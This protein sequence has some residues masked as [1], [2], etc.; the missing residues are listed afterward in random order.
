LLQQLQERFEGFGEGAKAVLQGR[1]E[2]AL[3]G[4]KAHAVAQGLEVKPEFGAA[5][6]ALLGS[7]A[8]AV[9]VSDGAVARRILSSLEQ[10]RIGP[11]ILRIGEYA[12]ALAQSGPAPAG[13]MPAMEALGRLEENHPAAALLAAC[14]I[15][16]DLDSFL[17][18]WKAN[19]GFEFL[20]VATRQGEVADRRGLVFG[21][22]RGASASAGGIVQREIDLRE[23][24]RALAEDQKRLEEQKAGME[25]LGGRLAAAEQELETRRS[26]VL[27]ATQGAAGPQAEERE[28]RRVLDEAATRLRRMERELGE[29]EQARNEAQER[30]TRAQAGLAG[31]ERAV[32]AQREKLESVEAALAAAR[33]ERDAKRDALAHARLELAERRQKVEVLDRGL[34]EM[35]RRRRQLGELLAQRQQEIETWVEQVGELAAAA[36]AERAR[37]AQLG[38]TL[39][40]AQQQVESVRVELVAVEGGIGGLEA[41]LAEVRAEADR[42][43]EGL[44]AQEIRLAEDRQ[45]A[46]FMAEEVTREF[47]ADVANLDWKD[48]VWHAGD[49]PEG[50]QTLDLDDEPGDEPPEGAAGSPAAD[51]AAKAQP[52]RPRARRPKVRGKPG[53]ADL[54]AL[55]ATNWDEI[56]AETDAL[57]QRLAT[58]GAVN[59]VAIEEYAELKQRHDF[60]QKQSGDLVSAKAELVKAIEEINRTSQQ[61]FD[62]T[63]EQ[64]RK[65][66]AYTFEILFGGGRAALELVEGGDVLES[67]IE[68]V[69][70][71]PGT[72][73]KGISLLSGGQR[74]LTAIALLFALYMV[75]PS[76]FCLL[77]E[78]DAPLD[79]SNI[80]RFT[81]LLRRFV[82][83]SQFIIIT[84]NKRTVAA[85][86]AIYGV[87]MEERG[88]S[89]TVSMRFN[90]ERG[91]PEAPRPNLAEAVVGT[92]IG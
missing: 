63:F 83:E 78:I 73:L 60:L 18:F 59:L 35:D 37:A 71:P 88:V 14:Y 17:A 85:A 10:E 90:H 4:A 28:A 70:Q 49:D 54:A 26:A 6:A 61:Q 53:E 92:R 5:V 74:A 47:S 2:P 55:D 30:W 16:D 91:E 15:A 22:Y 12:Q 81:E 39:L 69:A 33:A 27:A 87:T 32:L 46:Q 40:V 51:P 41:E 9:A 11:V 19:P 84:H 13:L 65:N 45:R 3:A 72:R 38:E 75:K 64:I 80:S 21:G 29:L 43:S 79:E 50:L 77:D 23:T 58:M 48:L 25:A 62:V 36:V 57:R 56:K 8:E 20:A 24:A 82:V 34:D 44:G 66:F 7:A 76:P 89:K 1:L 68:I 31:A 86:A 67:G 52:A 42:A